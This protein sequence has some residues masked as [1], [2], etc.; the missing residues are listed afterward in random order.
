MY[1]AR[2]LRIAFRVGSLSVLGSLQIAGAGTISTVADTLSTARDPDGQYISWVEHLVD[3]EDVNGGIPIR[4]GDGLKMAD[5]DGD[6][7]ED[8]VSAQEDSN[9]LRIAY[10]SSDPDQWALVSLASGS[11]AGAV[12]DVAVGDINNDGWLDLVFACEEGHLVYF[13]NPGKDQRTMRWRSVIP[14]PT[15]S[16]GSWIRAFLADVNGDGQLDVLAA[17]KAGSDIIDPNHG[18]PLEGATSLLW[19]TGD[20]LDANAWQ[21]QVLLREGV[22][23]IAMPVDI[24]RDGD[25]DILTSSRLESRSFILENLGTSGDDSHR[26][27]IRV[28][29][30]KVV[31]GGKRDRGW[32]GGTSAFHAVFHD[33]DGDGREDLLAVVDKRAGDH[34][35]P[36]LGWLRQP[37]SLEQP[38]RYYPVGQFLPDWL[39]GYALSDIDGDGDLDVIAGGYSGLNVI[40][41]AY[42]GA[43]RDYDEP[44]VDEAASTARL[45]WFENPG[46]L[47]KSWP[48]HDISRRVR[49]MFDE[50]IARDMDGD[51]DVDFVAT[52]GN[53]GSYDGVF[54]LE[55][56]RSATPQPAF[57][58]AREHESRAL[59]LPPRDWRR[60]YNKTQTTIAPNKAHMSMEAPTRTLNNTGKP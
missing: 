4:G 32:S 13:Q 5:L 15:V 6:G 1:I 54:W 45:A 46:I 21:E 57:I 31:P 9:H 29:E 14:A 41:R 37:P 3:S 55:Q 2:L 18:E 28:H 16:R 38:W 60:H 11:I 40:A 30:V 47:G 24:D 17:N 23:N 25:I 19:I 58:P 49:G 12:E 8:I 50:F 22:P 52:R 20:P 27:G 56:R 34:V 53:S 48:R 44:G 35:E 39:T 10:G 51:G 42:S 33:I 36:S 26:V 43:S 59:A 7:F